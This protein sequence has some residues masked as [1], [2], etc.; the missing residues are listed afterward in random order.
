MHCDG[1]MNLI[2]VMLMSGI[3]FINIILMGCGTYD[4]KYVA[5]INAVKKN[6]YT[7]E[8]LIKDALKDTAYIDEKQKE[9]L[10]ILI[11]YDQLLKILKH[12]INNTNNS[13]TSIDKEKQEYIKSINVM[14]VAINKRERIYDPLTALGALPFPLEREKLEEQMVM[15]SFCKEMYE[16][17]NLKD[18]TAKP[19]DIKPIKLEVEHLIEELEKLTTTLENKYSELEEIKDRWSNVYKK[20]IKMEMEM[21]YISMQRR[22]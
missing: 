10:K 13:I 20:L 18:E 2:R 9:T 3:F 6:P 22:R 19:D 16:R 7:A 15:M 17:L 8:N 11:E 4:Y 14:S 21:D 5:A 1:L 12:Q